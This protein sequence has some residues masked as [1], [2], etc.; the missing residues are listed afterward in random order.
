MV[1]FLGACVSKKDIV[2]FQEG[3]VDQSKV[4]NSYRTIFKPDDLLQ[5]TVSSQDL[6]AVKPFNLPVVTYSVATDRAVGNPI[7]QSYLVDYKGEIDFPVIGKLEVGGLTREETIKII[8][9][10]LS[11]DYVKNPTINIR[12][13]NYKVSIL[14]DV[15]KP[16]SY[17][18][19][20]ERISILD[21]I[22]L[23]GDLNISGERANIEVHREEKGKKNIYK[24]NLLSKEVFTSPVYYLQ[25]NDV[26][27]VKANW[28]KSQSAS[29]NQ[30]TGLFI[31]IASVLISLISILSR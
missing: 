26:I 23:A 30:N 7:Q 3:K 25:Q 15:R 9:D 29:Y 11:P 28:A 8:K 24:V 19:P 22:A 14:G 17:T 4:N 1:F 12:I 16:G 10:K 18:V 2:Y 20:N 5:I 27:Y 6:E 31:S 21:A 13:N